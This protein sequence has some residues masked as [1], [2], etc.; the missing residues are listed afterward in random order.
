[1]DRRLT[2][3]PYKRKRVLK[4]AAPEFSRSEAAG[5]LLRQNYYG[6]GGGVSFGCLLFPPSGCPWPWP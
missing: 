4:K 2:Q 6:R 1:M 5:V 3:T